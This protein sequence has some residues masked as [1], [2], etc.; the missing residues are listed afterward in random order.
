MSPDEDATEKEQMP[1]ARIKE[2]SNVS[3]LAAT[4]LWWVTGLCAI[5]ALGLFVTSLE[6]T[7]KV[8][9]QFKEGFGIK[10]GDAVRYRGVSIGEVQDVALSDDL[11]DITVQLSLTQDGSRVAREGTQFWIQRP[12]VSLNRV[13]GLET[14]VGANYV[15]VLPGAPDAKSRYKFDGVETPPALKIES[16]ITIRIQFQSGSGLAAGD[17]MKHRGIKVGEVQAVVL[18]E[19]LQS[20]SVTV[21]LIS[22]AASLARQGSRFWI[23]RPDVSLR[24]VRGLETVIGGRYIAVQPG[25]TDATPQ[26][27]FAGLERA[28]PLMTDRSEGGLEVILES[29][30]RLGLTS[31]APLNYR[32]IEVGQITSVGLASDASHVEAR[33]YVLPEYR[34]LIRQ[35]TRFWA[36]SGIEV[37]LG[38]LSGLQLDV[39]SLTTLATGG[40]ALA[41][42]E[43]AGDTVS[44]GFR[45]TLD[46]EAPDSWKSWQPSIA[47][48]NRALPDGVTTPHPLRVSAEWYQWSMGFRSKRQAEFWGLALQ[49][50]RLISLPEQMTPAEEVTIAV[51]G[52]QITIRKKEVN[53]F[54]GIGVVRV[55]LS[56]EAKKKTLK[57][58]RF[59][60]AIE[61]ED[62]LVFGDPLKDAIPISAGRLNSEDESNWVV[63]SSIA[64]DRDL[65]GGVAVSRNDGAI[66]GI[67][68]VEKANG[69]IRL[70]SDELLEQLR[71]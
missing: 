25:P 18:D 13:S 38:P 27:S 62:I 42:P 58:D 61:A 35:R 32:G 4:K 26:T 63:D 59:R 53:D 33:V 22:S 29:G 54:S 23:E 15:E 37:N 11:A 65:N 34:A 36:V 21:Q 49:G 56:A 51:A 52:E 31:G 66:V 19:S 8:I 43:N 5:I 17:A 50:G 68:L 71:K 24:G 7:T 12:Q 20:V 67:V 44:T 30:Q 39:D 48:G 1:V 40:V 6:R 55:N 10:S 69:T 9:V 28:P 46:E 70:F 47:L 3:A 45:F 16:P 2:R 57:L 14:V 41:V 60:K 64:F